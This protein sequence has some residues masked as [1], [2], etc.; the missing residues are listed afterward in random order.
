MMG[1]GEEIG[2]DER[3]A[4]ELFSLGS[5]RVELSLL[6][7]P[8]L[9][10]PQI[11]FASDTRKKLLWRGG[12]SIG[13]SWGHAWDIVHFARGTNPYRPTRRTPIQMMV[14][15]YSYAQMDPL[16]DKLWKLLPKGEIDPKLYR[17]EGQGIKG[18]KEPVVR[19]IRGPGAGS[20][21]YL[22]TYQQGA[23]R[24]Q[25]FQG[26]R[27]SFDEPPP[28]DIYGEAI[29][30]C[31]R[32][33]AELRITM[34]PTPESPPLEYLKK[35]VDEGKIHEMQTSYTRDAVTITG[36]LIPWSWKTE[37]DI[38]ED[39]LAYL[40]DERPMR[41]HGAWELVVAGRW[42]EV[43]GEACWVDGR[44]PRNRRWLVGIGIDHGTRP[45]RQSATLVLLDETGE[46]WILDEHRTET[47]SSVEDDARGI[48]AM[49]ARNGI[50][51]DKVDIWVGD[52][53]TPDSFY[54]L[55]KSNADL[56]TAL[57]AELRMTVR[58]VRDR[59]LI[60]KT[61][62]KP[63]NSLRP[64]VAKINSLARRG[65]LKV[66]AQAKGFRI[67]AM[68]WRGQVSSPLKDPVDSAR[69]IILELLRYAERGEQSTYSDAGL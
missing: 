43:V 27:L 41:E 44:W 53:A 13:K 47:V 21:I 60:I 42:L 52:R 28:V 68:G 69:Y 22:A 3:D 30:R 62:W 23:G 39:L 9:T 35:E 57:A 11:A 48:L 49:L 29:P 37:E 38:K 17:V 10:R 45:G 54:G 58:G 15:G 1:G 26:H 4:A 12:N 14:A 19:F 65:K 8:R 64:G 67:A 63:Q 51:W 25:G 7:S 59:G 6:N 66:H 46:V 50:P 5:D 32:F 2:G 61:A 18:Y 16:L 31:N 56:L 24:I 34:T 36:G 20:T 33:K 40:A 55:A